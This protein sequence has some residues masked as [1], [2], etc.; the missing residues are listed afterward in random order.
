MSAKASSRPWIS[1][2]VVTGRAARRARVLEAV[3]EPVE[4]DAA[5]RLDEDDVAVAEPRRERLEGRSRHR[6]TRTIRAGASPAA[7][8]PSAMPAAPSPTTTQ[9]VDR[10]RPPRRR[11]GG[12]RRRASPSSSI[13]P[14]TAHPPAGQPGQQ[15][16]RRD[17]R[18]RRGVVRVVDDGDPAEPARAATRWGADQ[19]AAEP[20]RDLVE[21]QAGG[22]ADRG[23][24]ERVVDRQPAERRDAHRATRALGAQGEA[25][26]VE[27]GRRDRLRAD[28]GI[29]GEAVGDDSRAAE[30]CPIRRTIGSSALRTAVPS[31][32]SAST[33][34][35]LA[36]SIASSEPIRARWTGWTAVTTPIRGRAIRGQVGDLAADVHPHLE[37]GRLVLRAEPQDRQRQADLVVLVA[38]VA[39]G[40]EA[41][42]ED[43]PRRPPWSTSWRCSR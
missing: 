27:T 19:P 40:P 28:V 1:S 38:L 12:P 24:G 35:P 13:S 10:R 31:G 37:H 25:H 20:G 16:E 29:V 3:D 9:P 23:R 22:Q 17:D 30:R 26:A 43:A 39:Q 8:A 34:S 41:G 32:G 4:P 6:G 11:R 21:R 42:R 2:T 36:A 15:V 33:S 7:R 14:R 5:R 18:P